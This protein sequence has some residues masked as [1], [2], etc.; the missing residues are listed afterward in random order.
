[1][2]NKED[3]VMTNK[4]FW[5]PQL[6]SKLLAW[7]QMQKIALPEKPAPCITIDREFGCQAYP[8]AKAL[9]ARF[10]ARTAGEPW[11]VLDRQLLGEVAKLSGYSVQQIENS[12]DTPSSLK[13]IFSMFLDSSHAEETE[14][15]DH[16]RSVIREFA[17]RGNCVIVGRGSVCA[18]QDLRN[19]IHVRLVAPEAFRIANIMASHEL[20]AEEAK[21]F[22]ERNKKQR[23]DFIARFT[24]ENICDPGL[25]H[26][27]INNA[28]MGI[29]KIA[30]LVEDYLIKYTC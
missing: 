24:K 26:L 6:E 2:P 3:P 7:H 20:S 23:D 30:T 19:C 9:V 17:R 4:E 28:R 15:F 27:V 14:I 29:D 21:K 8:L 16:L 22:I 5:T 13:S 25:Y 10:N 11:I 12:Q 18:A 1:M